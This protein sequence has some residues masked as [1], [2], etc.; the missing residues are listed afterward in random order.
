MTKLIGLVAAA[1]LVAIAGPAGAQGF[2][3]AAKIA[4]GDYAAA[5]R[6]LVAQRALYPDNVDLQ[7]NL[8]A[9]YANT[10]RPAQAR[11]LY[12]QV[13]T[14]PDEDVVTQGGESISAHALA[15]KGMARVPAVVAAR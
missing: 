13:A 9:V 2:N 3:G 5:E 6:D 7:L 11:A 14:Q 10:G 15:I 1:A 4:R 8:A 12:Q